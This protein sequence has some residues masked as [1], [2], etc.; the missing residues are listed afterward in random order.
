MGAEREKG[1]KAQERRAWVNVWRGRASFFAVT[2]FQDQ[3]FFQALPSFLK[4][5][6]SRCSG[7]FNSPRE[8]RGYLPPNRPIFISPSFPL[9]HLHPKNTTFSLQKPE[10]S[11]L[12]S[13]A[14]IILDYNNR[15]FFILPFPRPSTSPSYIQK[16]HIDA[17]FLPFPLLYFETRLLK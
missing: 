2:G 15:S 13:Q 12:T 11:Y 3:D 14:C 17:S 16:I 6:S 7:I 10:A 1:R 9:T 4:P 8:R 5:S